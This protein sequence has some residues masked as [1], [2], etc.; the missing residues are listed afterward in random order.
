MIEIAEELSIGLDS[1]VFVDDSA[2]ER[3]LMRQTLPAVLTLELPSIPMKYAET[4]VES[5][6]FERL[7]VT[8]EDRY[9]TEIYHAQSARRQLEQSALSLEDYLSSLKMQV[10]I[11]AVD[12][13]SLD[14]VA[15]LVRKTNQFNLTTRRH[16]AAQLAA[17]IA[18]PSY[19]V[20]CLRLTDRFGESGIVAVAI[21]RDGGE[22][23]SIDSFLLSCRVIGR[24]VETALLA[25]LVQWAR[26]RGLTGIEGEFIPTTKNAPAADFFLRHDFEQVPGESATLVWRLPI[27]RVEVAWPPYISA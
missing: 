19:G 16:S 27:D 9:R 8:T 22:L 24:T 18:D 11:D 25:Y 21:V 3:D 15:N 14:R 13:T 7:R 1:L 23:A 12:E 10:T 6:G 5:G 26:R 2:V 20:F 17:M 4:L